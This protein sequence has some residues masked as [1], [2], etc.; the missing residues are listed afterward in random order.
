MPKADLTLIQLYSSPCLYILLTPRA[1][2]VHPEGF[3][4]PDK[5]VKAAAINPFLSCNQGLFC[6]THKQGA[7]FWQ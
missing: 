3:T 2:Q 4:V 5:L 1:K 6:M 7:V